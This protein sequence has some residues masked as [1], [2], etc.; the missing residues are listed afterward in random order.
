MKHITQFFAGLDKY[1]MGLWTGGYLVGL[2]TGLLFSPL[3]AL[4][5][6][7]GILVVFTGLRAYSARQ[8]APILTIRV[9]L[10]TIEELN[11]RV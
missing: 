11:P 5:M 9:S 4:L 10:D 3:F 1:G 8:H 2:T 7:L 6:T